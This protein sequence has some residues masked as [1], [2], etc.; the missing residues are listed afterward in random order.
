M[1]FVAQFFLLW[2]N[3]WF[4]LCLMLIIGLSS[5]YRGRVLDL[6]ILS[7]LG[8][9]IN[10]ALKGTFQVPLLPHLNHEGYAF[11]SGHMQFST[12]FYGW[13]MYQLRWRYGYALGLA[14]LTGIGWGLIACHYHLLPDVMMGLVVGIFYIASYAVI[15]SKK[16]SNLPFYRV[17]VASLLLIYIQLRYP[18]F[19]IYALNTYFVFLILE[20][21]KTYVPP[22]MKKEA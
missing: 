11:P 7:L 5:K 9:L 8:I 21:L 14:L 6:G 4:C 13:L 12:V 10:V 18:V 19:P 22:A 15:L 1:A 16:P 17:I 3:L 2:S 20:I